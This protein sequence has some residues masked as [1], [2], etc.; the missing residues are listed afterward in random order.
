MTNSK[1]QIVATIGP[2]SEKEEI[3]RAMIAHGLDVAR[4]NF[5]WG[6]VSIRVRQI[7][8]I[9]KLTEEANKKIPIIIDLPG[10]RQKE[11]NGHTYD[12]TTTSAVT[13]QDEEFI[14]FAVEHKV[15]FVA[16]SFVG[17]VEDIKK[18]NGHKV[19]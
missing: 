5:S 9:R 18:C 8:L 7:A 10:P 14:K 11:E 17:G 16:V 6:D 3:L 2:A 1:A 15:D 12:H 19:Y 13:E 4:F